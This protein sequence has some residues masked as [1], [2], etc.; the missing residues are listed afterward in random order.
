M[1]AL[2]V[3]DMQQALLQDA[4]WQIDAVKENILQLRRA[5]REKG[6]PVIYVRHD[7]GPETALAKGSAGWEIMPELAPDKGEKVFDKQYNSAFRGTGLHDYLRALGVDTLVL[8]GM[9]TEYCVD[10]TCKVA[11]ELGYQVIIPRNATTTCD[12]DLASGGELVRY[13]ED[14]IWAGRYASVLPV[15]EVKP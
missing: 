13:F 7:D 1:K 15:N 3:I 10:A 12:C 9:Q 6:L 14:S 8:C 5:F 11:F 2:I 4:P